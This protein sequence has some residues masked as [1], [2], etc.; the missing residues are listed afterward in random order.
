VRYEEWTKIDEQPTSAE[1]TWHF[2]STFISSSNLSS[3]TSP[4]PHCPHHGSRQCTC[5]I[6]GLFNSLQAAANQ[7][8]FQKLPISLLAAAVALYPGTAYAEEPVRPPFPTPIP[9]ETIT[10]NNRENLSTMTFPPN[11]PSLSSRPPLALPLPPSNLQAQL[12]LQPKRH[13]PRPQRTS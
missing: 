11:P 10:N 12:S 8:P 7:L 6:F 4:P 9:K 2:S 13:R 3:C 5:H 1:K